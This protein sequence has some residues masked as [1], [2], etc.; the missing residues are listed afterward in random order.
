M[1]RRSLTKIDVERLERTYWLHRVN[2]SFE[3]LLRSHRR[4]NDTPFQPS[5]LASPVLED[6]CFSDFGVR[7]VH[8]VDFNVFIFYYLA[9]SAGTPKRILSIAGCSYAVFENPVEAFKL[10]MTLSR[11][12]YLASLLQASLAVCFASLESLFNLERNGSW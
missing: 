4:T 3:V 10:L 2:P 7:V 8:S 5:L 1:K 9:I 6:H 11:R 12:G